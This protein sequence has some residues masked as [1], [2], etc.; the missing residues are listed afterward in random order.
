MDQ[1]TF[2]DPLTIKESFA[3]PLTAYNRTLHASE[4]NWGPERKEE[5]YII[6]LL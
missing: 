1:L 2:P 6:H 5:R 4:S 3:P